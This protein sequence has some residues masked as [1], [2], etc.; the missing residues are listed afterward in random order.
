MTVVKLHLAEM[1]QR[2]CHQMG[3]RPA[4][5]RCVA[6]HLADPQRLLS[7]PPCL[8]VARSWQETAPHPSHSPSA[9]D[10]PPAPCLAS[11]MH[12]GLCF[13]AWAAG[14]AQTPPPT[15]P[16]ATGGGCGPCHWRVT[17]AAEPCILRVER[18]LARRFFLVL[19]RPWPLPLSEPEAFAKSESLPDENAGWLPCMHASGD[20]H[21]VP[22]L[23]TI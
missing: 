8:P 5:H 19:L 21:W 16:P 4:D 2:R 3:T 11:L 12:R 20:I 7:W 14:W 15:S 1:P 23:F 9:S 13:Q 17:A 6:V 22:D 10:P 18:T